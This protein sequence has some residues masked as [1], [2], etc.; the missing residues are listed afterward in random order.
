ME[1]VSF[2][3][4]DSTKNIIVFH[5]KGTSPNCQNS[6]SS[7]TTISAMPSIDNDNSNNNDNKTAEKK[8]KLPKIPN[9]SATVTSKDQKNKEP[10]RKKRKYVQKKKCQWHFS[11][12]SPASTENKANKSFSFIYHT[13]EDIRRQQLHLTKDD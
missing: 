11:F 3:P 10:E 2:H 6:V 9:T 8:D 1:V 4:E 7:A 5:A 12:S 13:Q